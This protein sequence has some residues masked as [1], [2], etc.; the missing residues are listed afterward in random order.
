VDT[1]HCDQQR[2]PED[3]R[4]PN[5]IFRRAPP[6]R[7]PIRVVVQPRPLRGA[8]WP[9]SLQRRRASEPRRRRRHIARGHAAQA[10]AR[11]RSQ[12]ATAAKGICITLLAGKEERARL[13]AQSGVRNE[14]KHELMIDEPGGREGARDDG[15]GVATIIG[16]DGEAR[17]LSVMAALVLSL[18]PALSAS[19]SA[20][21]LV[22]RHVRPSAR[23]ALEGAADPEP[24]VAREVE[25]AS[26]VRAVARRYC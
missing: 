14:Q 6:R 17:W 12:Q 22:K 16:A 5:I 9:V 23:H 7:C 13:L 15:G 25:R 21:T 19:K 24:C 2:R 4:C 11:I 20:W 1:T 8:L 18:L 10:K 3:V 26:C